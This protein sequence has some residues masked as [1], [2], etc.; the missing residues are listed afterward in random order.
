MDTKD[1]QII[2]ELQKNGRLTNLELAERVNLSPSPCLRRLR[3]LESTGV[4]QGYAAL[5]DQ[6][7]YG[8]PLTVFVSVAL[9]KH[10]RAAVR[11]FEEKIAEID[12]ILDCFL[13][14][15]DADY[16]LR[17]VVADLEVYERFVRT[18][19]HALPGIRSIDSRFAYGVVK[20]THVYPEVK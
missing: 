9:E 8:V 6:K 14:T 3:N 20:S 15:G 5:V 1:R 4:I 10:S 19:L 12:A 16:M 17:V 13:T 11:S 2:R 18:E 7:A